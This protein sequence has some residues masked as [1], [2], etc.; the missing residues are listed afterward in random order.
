MK[1]M[2]LMVGHIHRHELHDGCRHE[3]LG[4]I[5]VLVLS[6]VSVLSVPG[7]GLTGLL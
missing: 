5:Y 3:T 1:A 7:P 6:F 2:K 4:V